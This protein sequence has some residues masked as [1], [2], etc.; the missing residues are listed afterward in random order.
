VVNIANLMSLIIFQSLSRD[1]SFSFMGSPSSDAAG[2]AVGRLQH[3]G[4]ES[5]VRRGP[6]GL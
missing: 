6:T 5:P 3:R 4:R 1:A 2:S